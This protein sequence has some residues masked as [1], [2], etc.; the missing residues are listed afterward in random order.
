M[1]Q[2]E[3]HGSTKKPNHQVIDMYGGV[4]RVLACLTQINETGLM[5][6]DT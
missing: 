5:N 2:W 3:W 6:K 4:W 1:G